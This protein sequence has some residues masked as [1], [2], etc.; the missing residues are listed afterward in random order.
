MP[1]NLDAIGRPLGPV[2]GPYNAEDVIL[3][4]L[5][6]GCGFDHLDY[7]HEQYLKALPTF[8]AAHAMDFFLQVVEKVAADRNGIVH[9]GHRMHF[10]API[11]LTGETRTTGYIARIHDKGPGTGALIEA[12]FDIHDGNARH[13]ASG[14]VAIFARNDGGFG[15]TSSPAALFEFPPRPPDAIVAAQP[16]AAQPLLYR[17]TGD[18]FALHAD[19]EFA[20]RAGFKG[21]VMHGLCT[22]GFATVALIDTFLSGQPQRLSLLAGRFVH[23]LYPGVPISTQLW[24]ISPDRALWRTVDTASGALVIDRGE[25]QWREGTER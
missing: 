19:P 9:A 6:V 2:V 13:L 23:P 3:Y 12:H 1:L 11:P 10:H 15:G 4:A 5:A 22:L 7:C 17:L 16:Q 18:R 14:T 21:P 8:R 24:Q 25:A 20:R